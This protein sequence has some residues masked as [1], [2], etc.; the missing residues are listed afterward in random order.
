M[1]DLRTSCR[2]ADNRT[3]VYAHR[4]LALGATAYAGPRDLGLSY[5]QLVSCSW[6]VVIFE[7]FPRALSFPS[8]SSFYNA[9]QFSS[10]FFYSDVLDQSHFSG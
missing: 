2:Q 8:G 4:P 5:S 6:V 7:R 9:L 10:G 1:K 3:Q